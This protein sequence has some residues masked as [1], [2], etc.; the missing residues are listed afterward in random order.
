[1]MIKQILDEIAAVSGKND[2]RA[3]L[4]KYV[5]NELLKEVLYKANS[6]RVKFWI[7][8]IPEY[9]TNGKNM[10]LVWAFDH[11]EDIQNREIRGNAAS[12]HLAYILSSLSEGD[13]NIIER[14][15]KK[16]LKIGMDTGI[17]EV[18]PD[19]IEETPYMG[20][21]SFSEKLAKDIFK[22]GEGAISQ[23]KMDGTYRNAIIQN[24]EVELVSRQGE[25]SVL[26]GALFLEQLSTLPDCVLNGELTIDGF[27]RYEANGMVSSIM[28]ILKNAEERGEKV[29]M[30]KVEEFEKKH[31][32]FVGAINNM[33]YTV[34]DMITI[35][36]YFN[37]K[38][39]RPYWQRLEVLGIKLDNEQIDEL[40]M[41]SQ[42]ETRIVSSYAEAMVHFQ[43]VLSRGLE[44]TILKSMDGTW[45]DGKPSWQVKMKLEMSIDLR[46]VEPVFGNVGTKYEKFING[47]KLE[48]SDGIIKTTARGVKESEMKEF[49]EMGDN[50]IG[51]IMET[52]SCGLS[53]NEKGEWSLLHPNIV[54]WRKDKT[55]CDSLESAQE[56][57][58]MAK[59]LTV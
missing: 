3:I 36:E 49:T 54:E 20:A 23:I 25:V 26:H 9:T 16:D 57:E 46:V 38:S 30:K 1:M 58:N 50:M 14:V 6:R 7:K 19:L 4:K 21:K 37:K 47:F 40:T 12:E 45:K 43:E 52:K 15:I 31:G 34:W 41:V 8:Q 33:R 11:L 2:K 10:P 22:K 53:Q 59:S 13:A 51:E 42:V 48:S 27:D 39:D 56:I 32:S 55:T 44:G 17:N 24:G 5:D 29:T 18:I 35:E 28:D